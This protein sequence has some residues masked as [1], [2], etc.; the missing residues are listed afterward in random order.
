MAITVQEQLLVKQKMNIA[1]ANANPGVQ[2]L[3]KAF[4]KYQ[5]EHGSARSF[6]FVAV[7]DLG[8][9]A[10]VADAACKV[11]FIYLKKGATATGAFFK[12]ADSAS[13]A[14]TTA[15][16]TVQ[17]LNAAS[18]VYT[19]I[20]VNGWAQGS[21]FTIGSDTTADGNTASTSGD[22]PNGFVVIGAP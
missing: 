13:S 12:A 22:G 3:S 20:N 16:D 17:E 4:W 6:Q 18:Q 7:S 1:L 5:S 19:Q 10:I 21:G 15:S 8:A 11:Y 9:D 2:L 14:G